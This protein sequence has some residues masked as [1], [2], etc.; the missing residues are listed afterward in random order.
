[1]LFREGIVLVEHNGKII[2]RGWRDRN[3]N[4]WRV[5]IVPDKHELLFKRGMLGSSEGALDPRVARWPRVEAGTS[6]GASANI[7]PATP[8]EE[9]DPKDSIISM[10]N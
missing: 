9:Y 2:L 10:Q 4:L 5:P 8:F 6:E 3:I 7:I 1:M